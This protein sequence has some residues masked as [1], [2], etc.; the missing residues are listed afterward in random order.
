METLYILSLQGGGEGSNTWRWKEAGT[1]LA[2]IGA[3]ERNTSG[4]FRELSWNK[5]VYRYGAA[6]TR[7]PNVTIRRGGI[8]AQA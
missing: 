6:Y 8:P 2:S 4:G 1:Q 5:T 3:R 7:I